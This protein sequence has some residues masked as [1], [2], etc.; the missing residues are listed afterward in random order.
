MV[1]AVLAAIALLGMVPLPARAAGPNQPVDISSVEVA[2]N[3]LDGTVV[4]PE[5]TAILTIQTRYSECIQGGACGDDPT[6]MEV[7]VGQASRSCQGLNG[8]NAAWQPGGRRQYFQRDVSAFGNGYIKL[9]SPTLASLGLGN[10]P[11]ESWLGVSVR[12]RNSAGWSQGFAASIQVARTL[13]PAD[14]VPTNLTAP[15]LGSYGQSLT[16]DLAIGNWIDLWS[17][18]R[19]APGAVT[20]ATSI[21]VQA[22]RCPDAACRLTPAQY[23]ASG[24]DA[25]CNIARVDLA[26]RDIGCRPKPWAEITA[27]DSCWRAR[28]QAG[29]RKGWSTWSESA[30]KCLPTANSGGAGIG[31]ITLDLGDVAPLRPNVGAVDLVQPSPQRLPTFNLENNPASPI[32]ARG[33]LTGGTVYGAT[34]TAWRL[35]NAWRAPNLLANTTFT[36]FTC[37]GTEAATCTAAGT[38]AA[39]RLVGQSPSLNSIGALSAASAYARIA[40]TTTM[41]NSTGARVTRTALSDW[42]SV[43]A[44]APSA[45]TPTPTASADAPAG[46]GAGS[47][48]V[49]SDL[50]AAVDI[51]PALVAAGVDGRITPLVGTDGEGTYKGTTLK[52][53]VPT[54]EPRGVKIRATAIVTPRT[55]GKV[56]F[57]F[58]RT[59]PDGRVRVDRTRKVTVRGTKA[60]ASWTF[61]VSKPT[62]TYL[63]IVR[64]VPSNKGKV[65]AMVTKAIL[66]K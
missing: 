56:W 42:V 14:T 21:R 30:V 9:D 24:L 20:P 34:G 35:P 15:E 25:T 5:G 19:W 26:T 8:C 46:S 36:L 59:L 62:G 57:T 65:G 39:S 31:G 49:S 40:Q 63:L 43:S 6:V 29:N 10:L 44:A 22:A 53:Q 23:E 17:A 33:T 51:P 45:P 1:V 54:V 60:R 28:T 7:A 13:D 50:P 3:E 32:A 66:V 47:G 11:A 16:R 64:F 37:S 27:A 61:A 41:L 48:A 2:S 38:W 52:V 58:T 4:L 12:L 55:R 18:G